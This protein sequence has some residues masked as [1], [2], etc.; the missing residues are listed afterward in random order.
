VYDLSPHLHLVGGLYEGF[1][2]PNLDDLTADNT[3][4]QTG[5]DS[6]S[7]NVQPEHAITYEVGFKVDT[8]RLRLQAVEFWTRI[9]D[10]I[11]REEIPPGSGNFIRQ[12]FD[13]YINGTELTGEYLFEGGWSAYGNF[14]YIFGKDLDRQEPLSRTPPTQ[15]IAGLRWRHPC[16]RSWFDAYTWLVRRQDRY[17]A[18]AL[19]DSRFP[20]GGTPGYGTLNLR[21]GTALGDCDNHRLSL[22]LENITDK[23]YRV[24]GSGVDGP[25]FNAILGYEL[26]R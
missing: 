6:P 18:Q 4:L 22:T 11:L 24:L 14:W 13:V 15:G 2:A 3:V 26:L 7:L 20:A 1:R 10:N 9:G 21:A 23:A 19:N 16:N 17:A 12:N 8:P 25:G 5:Q